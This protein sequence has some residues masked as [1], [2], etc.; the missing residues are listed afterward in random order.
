MKPASPGGRASLAS[1]RGCSPSGKAGWS[2][3]RSS[4]RSI[5]VSTVH[6]SPGN[7]IHPCGLRRHVRIAQWRGVEWPAIGQP[8]PHPRGR[9]RR[10]VTGSVAGP[11]TG[12]TSWTPRWAPTMDPVIGLKPL[13]LSPVNGPAILPPGTQR[14]HSASRVDCRH[15][16]RPAAHGAGRSRIRRGARADRWHRTPSPKPSPCR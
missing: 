10:N 13:A 15:G 12:A 5:S 7:G 16:R 8:G 14:S 11:L 2:M 4:A 1:A 6:V 3:M 9:R